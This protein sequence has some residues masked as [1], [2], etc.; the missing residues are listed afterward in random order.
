MKT[1]NTP[2]PT[3]TLYFPGSRSFLGRP[4]LR[5]CRRNLKFKIE[6]LKLGR[7]ILNKLTQVMVQK[8]AKVRT[9]KKGILPILMR[10][11][12]TKRRIVLKVDE[13]KLVF[14]FCPLG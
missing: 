9:I 5:L 7:R 8:S 3:A 4:R 12:L 13:L 2:T 14:F 6:N 10:T 11:I 1:K